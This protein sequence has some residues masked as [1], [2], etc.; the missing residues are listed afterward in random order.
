MLILA[1]RRVVASGGELVRRRV[2]ELDISG[3][4]VDVDDVVDGYG[5]FF[6]I[7]ASFISNNPA[8]R[9]ADIIFSLYNALGRAFLKQSNHSA[10]CILAIPVRKYL[11]SSFPM[12]VLNSPKIPTSSY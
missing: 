9:H 6:N 1:I 8:P 11:S 3:S 5:S 7:R 4:G 10:F 2:V 12:C